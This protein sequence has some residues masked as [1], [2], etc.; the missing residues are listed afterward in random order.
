MHETDLPVVFQLE[1]LSQPYP[2][3][4]WFFRRQMRTGASCWV[5]ELQGEIIGFGI[6]KMVKH[7]A[8]IMNMCVAHNYRRQ[9]LGRRILI[10]LLAV[11]KLNHASHAWLEVRPTN[12]AAILLYR[13]MGFR[14][15]QI[16]RAYYL[17]PRGRQNAIVMVRRL[18]TIS[19][20]G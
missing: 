10:H 15:K 16:R 18:R 8:H 17:L 20:Q 19:V 1:R 12:R 14:R 5:L 13:K 9:G 7:W 6:V 2:W 3:P 4:L 11:A